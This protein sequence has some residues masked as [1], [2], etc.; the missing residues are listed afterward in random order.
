[1]MSSSLQPKQ[2]SS[3]DEVS[4]NDKKVFK[5]RLQSIT[6]AVKKQATDEFNQ[7]VKRFLQDLYTAMKKRR[8]HIQ[9]CMN[10]VA[11]ALASGN[12]SILI[13]GFA[14]KFAPYTELIEKK[15]D[16]LFEECKDWE[17]M[18]ALDVEKT[19]PK[20]PFK[21][22]ESI[23]KYVIELN[24][25]AGIYMKPDVSDEEVTELI[26]SAQRKVNTFV[27]KTGKLPQN[28]ADMVSMGQSVGEEVRAKTRPDEGKE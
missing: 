19:W 17:F 18:Q 24:I 20:M 28:A 8:A 4:E 5:A 10:S 26:R 11:V 6:V 14:E 9:S 3:L 12:Q 15:D 13:A 21:M 1:M 25:R 22:K 27:A 2:S 16:K 7:L 23:W